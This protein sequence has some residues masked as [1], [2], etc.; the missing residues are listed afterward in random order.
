MEIKEIRAEYESKLQRIFAEIEDFIECAVNYDEL[1]EDYGEKSNIDHEEL[2]FN[3]AKDMRYFENLTYTSWMLKEIITAIDE[4][5]CVGDDKKKLHR[6]KKE[7]EMLITSIRGIKKESKQ[8][9]EHEQQV[10]REVDSALELLNQLRK[11]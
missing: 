6:V 7:V 4:F 1:L 5:S 9:I 10:I 2:V 8:V 3:D 11:E